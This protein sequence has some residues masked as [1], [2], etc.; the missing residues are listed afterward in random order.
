VPL[1][2][3]CAS[4]LAA[5]F[6][7]IPSPSSAV[8]GAKRTRKPPRA[9]VHQRRPTLAVADVRLRSAVMT[10][11]INFQP[12]WVPPSSPAPYTPC[13][14]VALSPALSATA[15]LCLRVDVQ[16]AGEPVAAQI[17]TVWT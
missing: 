2:T 12:A 14:S 11:V 9:A 17:S 1:S 5:C 16:S 15:Q 4:L 8:D 10:A 3:V 13:P 7:V 6:S